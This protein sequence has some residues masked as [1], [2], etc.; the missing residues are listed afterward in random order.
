MFGEKDVVSNKIDYD[1]PAYCRRSEEKC[2]AE[3]KYFEEL[4]KEKKIVRDIITKIS[5]IQMSILF[6]TIYIPLYVITFFSVYQ[7]WSNK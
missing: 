3:G 6:F 2:G 7:A 1:S 4:P 5:D